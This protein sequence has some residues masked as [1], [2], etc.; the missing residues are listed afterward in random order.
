MNR[1]DHKIV[2]SIDLI[3]ESV[4]NSIFGDMAEGYHFYKTLEESRLIQFTFHY[5][6]ISDSSGIIAI[7]PL[8]TAT[9]D[10]VITA[11]GFFKAMTGRL[12]RIRPGLLMTKTLFCGSPF[13][14]NG[15]L[16]IRK[17]WQDK[18]RLMNALVDSM[19]GLA[20]RENAGFIVFK[21]FLKEHL[22]IVDTLKRRGFARTN[23]LP[24]V[25]MEVGFGS[26][27]DYFG[28][29]SHSRRKEMR[30]KIRKAVVEGRL[31]VRVTDEIDHMADDIYRLYMN[32]YLAGDT[33]FELLTKDFFINITKRLKPKAKYFL[34]YINEKLAAFN[35]CFEHGDRLIDK[36]IGFD[37]TVSKEYNLY[38]VSWCYNIEHC[39]NSS[40]RHYQTGQTDYAPKISLGG[41][42]IPLYAYMKHRNPV[43]DIMLKSLSRI[44]T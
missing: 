10:L 36:F 40:I 25:S 4:W 37:Y 20:K 15:S 11:K 3:D 17:D 2:D 32:T 41:K 39:L 6:I 43:Y 16:G 34:Y 23:S 44:A 42:H 7:A 26:L 33:K 21:D 29:L 14:E 18:K 24:S 35:L 27:D 38:F 12:R 9:L 19:Q 8:F 22:H 31:E 13:G 30:R 28:T 5:S 1:L